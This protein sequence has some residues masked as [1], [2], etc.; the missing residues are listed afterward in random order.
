MSTYHGRI[1]E[2]V[3]QR[4][5]MTD[6]EPKMFIRNPKKN[7]RLFRHPPHLANELRQDTTEIYRAIRSPQT[8]K[9][10]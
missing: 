8:P 7:S 9:D 3:E 2:D 1:P 5:K 4:R 6:A 10:P